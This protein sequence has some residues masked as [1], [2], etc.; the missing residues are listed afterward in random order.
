MCWSSGLSM[1]QVD[2]GGDGQVVG[3]R[4]SSNYAYCMREVLALVQAGFGRRVS[5]SYLKGHLKYFSCGP[6]T[7]CWGVNK[8]GHVYLAW[9]SSCCIS[10][11]HL[12]YSLKD[13]GNITMYV[14]FL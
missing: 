9:V 14:F 6:A 5:W 1:Q 2:A 11:C 8:Y 4:P 7:G 13:H 12:L 10:Y 3:V